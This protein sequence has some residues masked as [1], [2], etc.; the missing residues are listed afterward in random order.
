MAVDQLSKKCPDGT[1]LGQSAS[2]K[3][4][5]YGTTPVAQPGSPSGNTHTPTAGSTTAVYV[6]TTFDG[7]IGS[8]AYTIGDI[9]VALK[10]LGLLAA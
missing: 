7:S 10:N 5:F 6:N 8:S 1:A 4:G 9:V 2:D 3:V